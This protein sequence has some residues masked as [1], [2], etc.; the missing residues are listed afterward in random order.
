MKKI[1]LFILDDH[2]SV[3]ESYKQWLTSEGYEIVGE[4]RSIK[5]CVQ[6]VKKAKPDI[7][8]MDIDFPE[9]EKGGLIAASRIK[10]EIKDV[11]IIFISHYNDPDVI[12]EAFNSGADGYF[13]KSDELKFLKETIEKVYNNYTIVSPTVTKNLLKTISGKSYHIQYSHIK[14]KINLTNQE[15]IVLN[16]IA[17][18]LSNKEI[19][20]KLNTNEKRIKNIISNILVKLEAR[21]R[22]HAVAKGILLGIIDTSQG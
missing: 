19:A 13:S 16:Y 10:R 22:A 11:K 12:A 1:K 5:D 2:D 18:G 8:L 20:Q 14:P 21:N 6:I 4:G 3:R 9:K 7:V 17:E 15:T